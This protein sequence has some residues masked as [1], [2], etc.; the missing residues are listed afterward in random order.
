MSLNPDKWGS[1]YRARCEREDEA[2][3]LRLVRLHTDIAAAHAEHLATG[4]YVRLGIAAQDA[5]L[6]YERTETDG[7]G[8]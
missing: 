8:A 5:F 4:D 6:R 7:E 1:A 2:D 3:R